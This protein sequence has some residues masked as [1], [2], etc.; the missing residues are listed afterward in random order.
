V[1]AHLT[2][3]LSSFA[4]PVGFGAPS[5]T[6]LNVSGLHGYHDLPLAVVRPLTVRRQP[7]PDSSSRPGSAAW[8]SA[9]MHAEETSGHLI[10]SRYKIS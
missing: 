6:D 10:H 8:Q 5:I 3:P 1:T 9:L 2:A 4:V 7:L